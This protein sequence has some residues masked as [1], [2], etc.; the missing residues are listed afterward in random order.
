MPRH[1]TTRG[2]DVI[3]ARATRYIEW[4]G[5]LPGFGVRVA[6]T[7]T[8]T[9]LVKY[10]LPTGRV[11]WATIGRVGTTVTSVDG[12]GRRAWLTG[13]VEGARGEARARHAR[14]KAHGARRTARSVC[15][16]GC[17]GAAVRTHRVGQ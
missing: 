10:R 9:F 5:I 14:R 4:D 7:G 2:I 3:Q 17:G 15:V 6:T 12:H 16:R 11:R 1:L 13:M 8:K